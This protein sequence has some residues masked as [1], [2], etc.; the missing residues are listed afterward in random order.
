MA[1]F[2]VILSALS[3]TEYGRAALA[4][5]LAYILGT[6]AAFGID[7]TVFRG[8]SVGEVDG[9][10]LGA[11]FVLRLALASA[12]GLVAVGVVLALPDSPMRTP[13]LVAFAA[14]PVGAL[15]TLQQVLRARVRLV[16]F[17]IADVAGSV[18]ALGLVIVFSLRGMEPVDVVLATVLPNLVVYLGLAVPACRA[19]RP[20]VAWRRFAGDARAILR[21]SRMIAVGDATVVT[22]YR[23]DVVA[24]G[25]TTGGAALGVYAAVYRFVDIAMYAQTIVI[26]AFFPRIARAWSDPAALRAT[27]VQVGG[28][29]LALATI[30]FITVVTLG[31]AVIELFG[32]DSYGDTTVLVVILMT[33]TA[34]MFLNRL[35]IQTLIAGGFGGRQAVCW[36]GGLTGAGLAFPLSALY[37][38]RGAGVAMLIGEVLVLG[39]AAVQLRRLGALPRPPAPG[40]RAIAFAAAAV[41]ALVAAYLPDTARLPAGVVLTLGTAAVLLLGLRSGGGLRGVD[42]PVA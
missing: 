38:E 32:G 37:A 13:L 1:T 17:A 42:D 31:P 10:G 14:M 6:A 5:T 33:V 30:A 8:L 24:L 7:P 9:H 11:A 25:A 41:A 3:P 34:L 28:L 15:V 35:L 16:P 26:G 36:V 23:A 4:V 19:L 22:Y 18:I 21:R 40:P 20:R 12:V 39:I 2:A 27:L 29:L